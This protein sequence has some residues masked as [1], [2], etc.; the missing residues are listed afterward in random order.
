[1][2]RNQQLTANPEDALWCSSRRWWRP[3][4]VPEAAEWSFPSACHGIGLVQS[5]LLGGSVNEAPCCVGPAFHGRGCTD[6]LGP[7]ESD[8]S[9]NPWTPDRDAELRYLSFAIGSRFRDL[10]ATAQQGGGERR[11]EAD[12]PGH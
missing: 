12:A 8:P 1:M 6:S 11:S 3:R 10:W 7:T 9:A 4:F 5:T 2:M